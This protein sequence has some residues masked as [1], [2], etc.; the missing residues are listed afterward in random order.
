MLF[1]FFI[2]LQSV[3]EEA[4]YCLGLEYRLI[5]CPKLTYAEQKIFIFW[6][7]RFFIYFSTLLISNTKKPAISLHYVVDRHIQ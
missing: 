6:S 1:I 2:Y 5:G 7:C 4:V 3:T